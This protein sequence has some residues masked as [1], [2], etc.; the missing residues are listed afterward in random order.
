MNSSIEFDVELIQRYDLAGPR[1]TSYPTAVQFHSQFGET[2]YLQAIS[3]SNTSQRPLSLYVHLPF[4]GT[5]CYYCACN[6][7]ITANRKRASPYLDDL[8][9]EIEL[10]AARFSEKRPV[11]QLH[12]GGG[13]PTFISDNEITNLMNKLRKHVNLL[14]ED[15]GDYSIEIDPREVTPAKIKLL[16]ELGFNRMSF[17]VQD[18]DPKV[19]AAVNRIQ[20]LEQTAAAVDAA[21]TFGFHSINIDLIYGLPFQTVDSFAL[22]LD[23]VLA[24][25]PDRL[26]VFNYAHLPHMFKV[27]KQ[28]DENTLPSAS[29]KLA[30][31]QYVIERLQ[32]AGYIYIGMD[33]FAKPDD[34]LALA[35][36]NGTLYRNF[37][38]YSTHAGCDLIGLG[39]TSIGMVDDTYSQNVK[40][41]EE[42]H[43]CVSAGKLP[44]YRGVRLT[45]DD[46]LRRALITELICLF[47]IDISN[48]EQKWNIN[49]SDYFAEELLQLAVMVNDGL[50]QLDKTTLH[51][52]PRGRL[53]IRNICMVFDVYLR[54]GQQQRF[55]KVI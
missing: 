28:M 40:T 9:L 49:F 26:S 47:K 35:Q 19:Q 21:R 16:R 48:F 8:Y 24:L 11:S 54:Q 45:F 41:L 36:E 44:V 5:V 18:F 25:N 32:Q 30:I 12:F 38:G 46:K 7:I 34:E 10:Q 53:L 29:T 50:I 55:S 13:T 4:C 17:G 15:Q 51:V 1:Y 31:L 20:S 6:K 37:Q 42:Y 52:L 3:D 14:A 23:K 22:T 43:T 27:Q 39:I 2:E 33:H